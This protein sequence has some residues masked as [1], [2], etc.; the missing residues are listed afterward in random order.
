M[1]VMME[2]VLLMSCFWG[3]DSTSSYRFSILLTPRSW[4]PQLIV[5]ATIVLEGRSMFISFHS[6]RVKAAWSYKTRHV[7]GNWKGCQG[8]RWIVPSKSSEIRCRS[9]PAESSCA[10]AVEESG[11]KPQE[12]R[13]S[14][15]ISDGSW[16]V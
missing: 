8:S 4:I 11:R 1:F 5:I 9:I 12:E 3:G 15:H 7:A 13:F 14:F 6:F 2:A 16:Q 10:T